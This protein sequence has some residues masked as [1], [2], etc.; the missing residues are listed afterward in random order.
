M[1]R[2]AAITLLLVFSSW[3]LP[4]T[5]Q[6]EEK[7]GYYCCQ[8]RSGTL[9]FTDN[10]KHFPPD[11]QLF[12]KDTG[13]SDLILLPGSAQPEAPEKNSEGPWRIDD[14]RLQKGERTRS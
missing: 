1:K 11:C 3:L 12:P 2:C 10:P 6:A 8:E 5:A 13:Q 4:W 14:W 9:F 7:D